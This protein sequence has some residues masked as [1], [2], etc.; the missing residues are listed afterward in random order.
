[1]YNKIVMAW[2][3]NPFGSQTLTKSEKYL[4]VDLSL[5]MAYCIK[6]DVN[7]KAD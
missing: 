1:M 6:M 2:L 5:Y 3:G 4:Y 7:Y